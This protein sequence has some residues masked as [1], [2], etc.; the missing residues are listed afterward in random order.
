M[1]LKNCIRC[2]ELTYGKVELS[3]TDKNI[4]KAIL[5]SKLLSSSLNVNVEN[6]LC[7]NCHKETGSDYQT[8]REFLERDC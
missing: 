8:L 5:G 7:E 2:D 4:L 6:M 1:N 3:T